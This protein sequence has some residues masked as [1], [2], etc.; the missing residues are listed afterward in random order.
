MQGLAISILAWTPAQ[1]PQVL[2]LLREHGITGLESAPARVTGSAAEYRQHWLQHGIRPCALQSLLYGAPD[3]A[4]FDGDAG[5]EQLARNLEQ[6]FALAAALQI[7]TLVFGSYA[8][9]RRGSLSFSAAFNR[10]ADFFRHIAVTAEHQ[11]VY[12]CLEAVPEAHGCDFITHHSEAAALV[13][14]VD[15]PHVCLHLDSGCLHLNGE[16]PDTVM[17]QY[18]QRVRHCHLSEPHLRPLGSQGVD[19]AAVLD[20]LR[21]Y[22]YPGWVSIEMFAGDDPEQ[23]L[24]P[25]L[26]LARSLLGR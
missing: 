2:P 15:H 14:A 7:D 5:R 21:R 23:S 8:Q 20:A 13:N 10:A 26:A 1:E 16:N 9:R 4:L 12:L 6:A 11:G 24:R 17:R 18:G 25:A 19:H 3:C 22:D